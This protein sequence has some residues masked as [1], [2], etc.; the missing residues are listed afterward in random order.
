MD[1]NGRPS[2]HRGG[3]NEGPTGAEGA[4]LCAL[5]PEAKLPG[6]GGLPSILDGWGLQTLFLIPQ[7]LPS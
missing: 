1:P 7:P 6:K 5:R 4:G 3:G 2:G